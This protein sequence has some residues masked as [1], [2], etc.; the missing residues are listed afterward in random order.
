MSVL[1]LGEICT[2][3]LPDGVLNVLTG[4]G[5]TVGAALVDHPGVDKVSF[6]GSTEVGRGIGRQVG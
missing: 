6:T 5:S 1:L 3:L 4:S 2:E